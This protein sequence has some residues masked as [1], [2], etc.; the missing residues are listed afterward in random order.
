MTSLSPECNDLKKEYD[1]CFNKWYANKFLQGDITQDCED[2]FK[3]YRA[4]IWKAIKEKKLDTLID[5]ARKEKPFATTTESPP[6][7]K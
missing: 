3:L 5:D 6:D 2:I 4:C 7:S 1:D